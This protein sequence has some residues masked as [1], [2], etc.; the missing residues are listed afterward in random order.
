MVFFKPKKSL[1][2]VFDSIP[3]TFDLEDVLITTNGEP[4]ELFGFP[5]YAVPVKVINEEFHLGTYSWEKGLEFIPVNF[6]FTAWLKTHYSQIIS[7]GKLKA[8]KKKR[9]RL[10][11]PL[12]TTGFK[13]RVQNSLEGRILYDFYTIDGLKHNF[14]FIMLEETHLGIFSYKFLRKSSQYDNNIELINQ[15]DHFGIW[16]DYLADLKRG[17]YSPPENISESSCM[18]AKS[19]FDDRENSH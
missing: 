17:V 3:Y 13:I 16:N 14:T 4:E 2:E 7:E 8:S 19:E 9:S 10:P 6:S 18:A 15:Q 11:L 5:C 1:E 12:K